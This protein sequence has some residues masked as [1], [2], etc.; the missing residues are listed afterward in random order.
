MSKSLNRAELIGNVVKDAEYKTTSQNT[1]LCI[2]VVATNRIWKT[3]TGEAK[4]EADFHRIVAWNKLAEI[5]SQIVKKGAKVYVEGR[6]SNKKLDDGTFV[7]EI[8][9]ED[10]IVLDRLTQKIEEVKDEP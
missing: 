4:E 6:I 2:F 1:P 7:H 8:V 5:C 3:S 10:I 9:A